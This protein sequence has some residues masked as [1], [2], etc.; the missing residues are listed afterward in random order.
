[1]SFME[2]IRPFFIYL[3]AGPHPRSLALGG[4]LSRASF[5]RLA[6]AAGARD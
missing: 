5:Q 2:V 6:L 1:M 3:L 4:A